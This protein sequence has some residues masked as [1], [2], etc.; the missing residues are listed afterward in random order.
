MQHPTSFLVAAATAAPRGWSDVKY[1]LGASLDIYI[2]RLGFLAVNVDAKM[3]QK[4][5][6]TFGCQNVAILVFFLYKINP[7]NQTHCNC[8]FNVDYSNY[9]TP[10]ESQIA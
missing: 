2:S 1:D 8:T 10:F 6:S 7:I 9:F 3:Y 5:I 4:W